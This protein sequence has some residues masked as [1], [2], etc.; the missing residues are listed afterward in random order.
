M[1]RE[2]PLRAN[3]DAC[4]TPMSGREIL[5]VCLG[6]SGQA[7]PRVASAITLAVEPLPAMAKGT[8][9]MRE[10]GVGM[11][12]AAVSFATA[13]SWAGPTAGAY[14]GG[15]GSYATDGPHIPDFVYGA[16]STANSLTRRKRAD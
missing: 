12:P 1:P 11:R 4:R 13:T 3:R 10:P 5:E 9:V 6:I 8:T 16:T 7:P 2:L 15:T 14:Q